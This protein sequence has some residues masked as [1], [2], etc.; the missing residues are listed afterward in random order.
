MKVQRACSLLNYLSPMKCYDSDLWTALLL[1][2]S[3]FPGGALGN[4][5]G[6]ESA[7]IYGAISKGETDGL[8]WYIDLS[9]EQVQ[10][11]S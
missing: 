7:V 8:Q 9:L 10:Y 2:D 6:L 11:E 5:Q 3:A 1:S 4:S